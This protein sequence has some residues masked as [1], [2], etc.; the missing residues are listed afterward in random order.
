MFVKAKKE[1]VIPS[2]FV[3]LWILVINL[4]TPLITVVPAW[5]MFLVSIF[6]FVMGEDLKNI[7][8]IFGGGISG[9]IL[10]YFLSIALLKLQP[11]WGK[12]ITMFILLAFML[13]LIIIGGNF[14]PIIFNNITFAFLTVGTINLDPVLIHNSCIGWLMMLIIGGTIILGGIFVIVSIVNKIMIKRT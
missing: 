1:Q 12:E 11:I 14:L 6:F 9:I 13:S 4:I 3:F 7:K 10:M 8:Q 5:P 2:I